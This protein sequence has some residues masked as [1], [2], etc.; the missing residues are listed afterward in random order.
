MRLS[1]ASFGAVAA[2]AIIAVLH[3]CWQRARLVALRREL[4]VA[5]RELKQL[6]RSEP[7]LPPPPSADNLPQPLPSAGSS[8][9]RCSVCMEMLPHA[10][11]QRRQAQRKDCKRKCTR[12]VENFQVTP[13]QHAERAKRIATHGHCSNEGV[14]PADAAPRALPPGEPSA[15]V[16]SAATERALVGSWGLLDPLSSAAP[17]NLRVC[18]AHAEEALSAPPGALCVDWCPGEVQ[19]T[20]APILW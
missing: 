3:A 6:A 20:Q 19:T 12:C 14:A 9:L 1:A 7:L 16:V 17:F 11:F 2:A 10:A 18:L 8:H 13:Q 15:V 5:R 4:D